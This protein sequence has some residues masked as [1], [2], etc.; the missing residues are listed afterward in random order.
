MGRRTSK[1]RA[2]GVPPD[3]DV[4]KLVAAVTYK[5]RENMIILDADITEEAQWPSD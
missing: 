1:I 3:A 4:E 5:Q 2:N